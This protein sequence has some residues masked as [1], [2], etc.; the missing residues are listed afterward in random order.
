MIQHFYVSLRSQKLTLLLISF[1][2]SRIVMAAPEVPQ[3]IS[4]SKLSD[5]TYFYVICSHDGLDPEEVKQIA[6]SKCLAS[7]AKLGEVTLTVR[8]KTIQS[9]TGADSTEVAEIQPLTKN[10]SCEWT[11]RYIEKIEN[12]FRVWLRCR[13]PRKSVGANTAAKSTLAQSEGTT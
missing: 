11:D 6:E 9:L 5:T 8:Q 3:W 1:L 12:G 10:I 7:A 2:I 13:I 4:S